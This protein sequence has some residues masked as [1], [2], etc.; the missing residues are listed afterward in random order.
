MFPK[1]RQRASTAKLIREA[2]DSYPD[3]LCFATSGGRPIL[4]NRKMNQLV[5]RLSGR[6]ISD[7]NRTWR[8]LTE[9]EDA[10]GCIRLRDSWISSAQSGDGPLVVIRFP[11]DVIWRFRRVKLEHPGENV[12]QIEASDVTQWYAVSREL[13][14]TKVRIHGELGKCI[15]A[16]KRALADTG[17]AGRVA[18]SEALSQMWEDAIRHLTSIPLIQQGEAVSPE[19]ELS[20]VAEMIGCKV[21]FR[22]RRPA[23]RKARLLLYAAV[24]EAL[25]NAVRHADADQL[26]VC[27]RDD[28]ESYHIEIF[29][30]GTKADAEIR[31]GDGLRDL[32]RR[33]EEA[34]GQLWIRCGGPKQNAAGHTE[35]SKQEQGKDAAHSSG[36]YGVRLSIVLPKGM[37]V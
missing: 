32:R 26:T 2:I 17:A 14:E 19:A 11:D 20:R 31:E 4:V 1:F 22:G 30:N 29:D 25:T 18:D 36:Q 5:L 34:G 24:R 23:E 6:T 10:G 15:I 8:N 28:G 37:E 7:A 12:V 27:T 16:T 9:F 13:L 21:I 35:Q 3:G 33:L